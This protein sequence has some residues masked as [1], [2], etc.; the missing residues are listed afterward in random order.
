MAAFPQVEGYKII[1]N[2]GRGSTS[3]VYLAHAKVCTWYLC[4]LNVLLHN[5]HD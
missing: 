5:V 1:R 2:I 3:T 4:Y